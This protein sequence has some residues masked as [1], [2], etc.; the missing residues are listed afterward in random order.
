MKGSEKMQLTSHA[1]LLSLA[2]HGALILGLLISTAHLLMPNRPQIIEVILANWPQQVSLD[3]SN[4]KMPSR[5]THPAPQP[6]I[7]KMIPTTSQPPLDQA[8]QPQIETQPTLPH[9]Q[10]ESI[11][12]K[13]AEAVEIPP[14]SQSQDATPLSPPRFEAAYLHNPKPNYPSMARKLGFQGTVVLRV[15]VG[16]EGKPEEIRIETSSGHSVLDDAALTAVKQWKFVPAL[17]GNV[18]ISAWVDVPIRY[19][20]E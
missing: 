13:G 1:I 4:P 8:A 16:V 20:L 18:P 5:P 10:T 2:L 9:T 15:L 7:E 6:P 12:S 3:A 11:P 19:R 17:E 14:N